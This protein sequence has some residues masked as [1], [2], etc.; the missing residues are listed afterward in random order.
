MKKGFQVII[1]TVL[2]LVTLLGCGSLVASAADGPIVITIMHHMGEDTKVSGLKAWTDGYTALHPEVTFDVIQ[3]TSVDEYRNLLRTKL[4]T[5]DAPEIAFGNVSQ[6][7]DLVEAGHIADLTGVAFIENLDPNAVEGFTFDGKVM[8]VPIDIGGLVMY[9]NKDIFA[10][11][12]LSLPTTYAEF[13]ALCETFQANGIMAESWGLG[14]GWPANVAEGTET[15]AFVA[16]NLDF[17]VDTASRAKKVA[18]FPDFAKAFEHLQQRI[19]LQ[20]GDPYGA[21]YS[22]SV[23]LFATGGTAMFNQ[24]TWAISDIAGVNPDG[25]FGIFALPSENAEDTLTRISVDDAFMV[26]EDS[27]NKD[28]AIKFFE[29]VVTAEQGQS[30]ADL[31]QTIPAIKGV[32]ASGLNS[33]AQDFIAIIASGRVINS[34]KLNEYVGAPR[35]YYG[36]WV[37]EFFADKNRDV[38]A[39]IDKLDAQLQMFADTE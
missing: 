12:G 30:W 20:M 10:E 6:Y 9:Y 25:N 5:D 23:N 11:N 32:D 26:M 39:Y 17:F 35:D 21:G 3:I 2:V 1:A 24:G 7:K 31:T 38:A 8:G 37:Q 19:D 16:R 34:D 22:D 18:D 14:D 36:G 27:K 4:N 33:M 15:Y 28:E 13:I 29:F